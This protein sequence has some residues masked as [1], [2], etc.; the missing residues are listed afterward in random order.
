M[1]A[2]QRWQSVS[3]KPWISSPPIRMQIPL[4][5]CFHRPILR[6]DISRVD[7]NA[8]R[9]GIRNTRPSCAPRPLHPECDTSDFVSTVDQ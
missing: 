1:G 6:N 7:L 5:S 9:G 3:K 2:S 8:I 4:R